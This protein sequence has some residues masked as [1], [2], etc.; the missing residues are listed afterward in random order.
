MQAQRAHFRCS[1]LGG[2]TG[3]HGMRAHRPQN[4]RGVSAGGGRGGLYMEAAGTASTW[5]PPG[6]P[7]PGGRHAGLWGPSED[8]D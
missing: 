3:I 1:E 2:R 8:I 6:R 4:R 7:L 5:R